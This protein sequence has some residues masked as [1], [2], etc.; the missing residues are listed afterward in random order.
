MRDAIRNIARSM[1]ISLWKQ[2][3]PGL[4]LKRGGMDGLEDVG[5]L[6]LF[7]WLVEVVLL[8]LLLLLVLL[9]ILSIQSWHD[10]FSH[11]RLQISVKSKQAHLLSPCCGEFGTHTRMMFGMNSDSSFT[12]VHL[13]MTSDGYLDQGVQ[14]GAFGC[15][16]TGIPSGIVY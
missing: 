1:W 6:I 16:N 8:L 14:T 5:N 9:R 7:N 11:S 2:P 3:R 13:K 4:E 15:F 12:W 10:C